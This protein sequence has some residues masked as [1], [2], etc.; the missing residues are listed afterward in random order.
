MF[1]FGFSIFVLTLCPAV[2]MAKPAAQKGY[3]HF[4]LAIAA[5]DRMQSHTYTA[6]LEESG[7]VTASIREC[8][9]AEFERIDRRLNASYKKTMQRLSV[10]S[11]ATLRREERTWLKTRLAACER[12]L[13]EDEGGTIWLIEM[14][15][16][17]LQ[18]HIRR[19]AWIERIKA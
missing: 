9:G 12:D 13:A 16:C 19:T 14:D 6:C 8:I 4:T 3:A 18:E 11:R 7:G 10:Q 2:V 17:A 15:D 5:A 1:K